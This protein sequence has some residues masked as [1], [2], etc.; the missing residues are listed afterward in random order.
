MASNDV[1]KLPDPVPDQEPE[2]GAAIAEV[3]Q[4]VADLLHGPGTVR[5]PLRLNSGGPAT[6]AA[7]GGGHG[8]AVLLKTHTCCIDGQADAAN[9]RIT[10]ALST[11]DD[12]T[13]PNQ[14][15]GYGDSRQTS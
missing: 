1:V 8:T 13:E 4:E 6:E 5:V 2:T 9:K 12:R 3:H 15:C 14:W 7:A 11:R 10:G